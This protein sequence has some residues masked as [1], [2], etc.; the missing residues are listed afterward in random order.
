MQRNQRAIVSIIVIVAAFALSRFL[1]REREPA[2]TREIAAVSNGAF[3]YYLIALSWS[4]TWCQAN[5]D[6]REQ[7]G[8]R[9]Y[10]F[11]LHGLWPQ[12]ERGSG[13]QDC[14]SA[15]RPDRAT[16]ERTLAFMPSRRLIEHEWRAH[17]ACTG[18]APTAYFEMSDHAFAR[19]RVP[20]ALA[21]TAPPPANLTAAA[22]GAA[23]VR[24]NPGLRSDMFGVIC[25]GGDL[26]EVRICVDTDLQFRQCGHG[27]RT[28]CPRDRP[29]RIPAVR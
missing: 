21:A 27:V 19:V 29:V 16:I 24:A 14:A 5:P 15:E 4:P 10:G 1:E 17:G 3:D 8:R 25:R 13:P 23:F 9:G 22:I 6:D 2:P 7:C 12:Y 18:L 28:R 26:A 11:I 20:E